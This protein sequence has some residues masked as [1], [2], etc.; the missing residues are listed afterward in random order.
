MLFSIEN[1]FEARDYPSALTRCMCACNE[2]RHQVRDVTHEVSLML[3][4]SDYIVHV[5]SEQGNLNTHH[6]QYRQ[7]YRMSIGGAASELHSHVREA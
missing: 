3:R 5:T 4:H 2:M 1:R 6:Y 7:C